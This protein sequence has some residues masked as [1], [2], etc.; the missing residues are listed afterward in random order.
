[1]VRAGWL[2][3]RQDGDLSDPRTRSTPQGRQLVNWVAELEMRG[4]GASAT[5]AHA[6]ASTTSSPPSPTGTSTGSTSPTLIRSTE[7]VLAYPMVDQDPLPR[8]SFGRVTLLGD[9]AHPMV[10]ARLERRRP[11]DPRRRAASPTQLAARGDRRRRAA[12]EYDRIRNAATAKM[13]LPTA[14]PAGRDPARG[15]RALRRPAV[16]AHRGRR[17]ARGARA[18]RRGLQAGRRPEAGR[19]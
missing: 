18:D 16:R 17:L 8:W 5:G 13:V 11:G 6:A 9:A 10:S 15:A 1:M 14:A 4:A 2:V 7:T 12:A 3:G 19:R